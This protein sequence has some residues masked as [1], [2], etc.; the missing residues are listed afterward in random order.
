MEGRWGN[1]VQGER[2]TTGEEV[3]GHV[4]RD[5]GKFSD[6]NLKILMDFLSFFKSGI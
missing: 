6:K 1:G 5:F 2:K 3:K 4:E